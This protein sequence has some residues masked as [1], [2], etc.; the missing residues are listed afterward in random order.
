MV[1][2]MPTTQDELL[3]AVTGY[4]EALYNKYKGAE[5]L[6]IF[7]HYYKEVKEERD[8]LEA[9]KAKLRAEKIKKLE[10]KNKAK[11]GAQSMASRKHSKTYGL[12]DDADVEG[13]IDYDPRSYTASS[14]GSQGNSYKRKATSSKFSGSRKKWKPNGAGG[15]SSGGGGG[16]GGK[17]PFVRKFYKKKS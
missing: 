14:S 15:K 7:K 13:N 4:T 8:R 3:L 17:K 10:E 6:K 16:G 11:M 12:V 1:E 5:M 9:E 2:K